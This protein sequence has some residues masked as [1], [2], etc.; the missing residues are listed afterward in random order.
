MKLSNLNI[1]ARLGATFAVL[2]IIV[3]AVSALAIGSLGNADERFEAFIE[4]VAKPPRWPAPC[5]RRSTCAPSPR[6]TSCS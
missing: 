2:A 3:V 5:A 1:G 6:A 4:G